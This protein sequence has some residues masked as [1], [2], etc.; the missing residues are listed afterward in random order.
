MLPV[1]LRLFLLSEIPQTPKLQCSNHKFLRSGA[2]QQPPHHSPTAPLYVLYNRAGTSDGFVTSYLAH[3]PRLLF[4]LAQD[5]FEWVRITAQG[6][7]QPPQYRWFGSLSPEVYYTLNC[8]SPRR[9][10]PLE[11]F[12]PSSVEKAR[13]G[14]SWEY[15]ALSVMRWRC[16]LR[17]YLRLW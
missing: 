13:R 17:D 11:I 1:E 5:V 8:P 6:A 7:P 16:W 9:K 12:L 10:R 3:H 2:K 4:T 14:A 15:F